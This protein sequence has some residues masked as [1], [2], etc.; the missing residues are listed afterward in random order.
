MK[1]GSAT[2]STSFFDLEALAKMMSNEYVMASDSYNIQKNQEI[3]ELLQ[4]KK[5]E[6]ELKDAELEIRRMENRQRDEALYET[7][8][9]EELKARLSSAAT[10]ANIMCC[11][12]LPPPLSPPSAKL[13]IMALEGYG[14]QSRKG[15]EYQRNRGLLIPVKLF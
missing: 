14:Y 12:P 6:L 2:S 15:Y 4:I 13:M 3:S 10:F 5:R 9:D 7:T 11:Q 8:T 1:A